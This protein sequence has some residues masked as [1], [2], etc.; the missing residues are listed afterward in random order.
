MPIQ[1]ITHVVVS[2]SWVGED[3]FVIV[4]QT[5]LIKAE[6]QQRVRLY[7]ST[8]VAQSWHEQLATRQRVIWHFH[9]NPLQNKSTATG[10]H[11][12]PFQSTPTSMHLYQRCLSRIATA[13]GIN[14]PL[15]SS[16]Y[17]SSSSLPEAPL[18]YMLISKE[19]TMKNKQMFI[20][21]CYSKL[22]TT[23]FRSHISTT[24]S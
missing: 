18:T 10:R 6:F 14:S 1:H 21:K 17:F 9:V 5:R 12:H 16:I 3:S 8:Q 23:T 24:C 13:L 2:L 15:P 20:Y 4:A 19:I 11:L 22:S 7:L